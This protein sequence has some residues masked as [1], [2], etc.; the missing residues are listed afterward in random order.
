M[1]KYLIDTS[2]IIEKVP[3]KL[4]KEKKLSGEII[5]TN[6]SMSE[7]ENQANRRQEIGFIG[8][9]EIQNLQKIKSKTIQLRFVGERP[10]PNQIKFAKAGEI[11]AIIREHA[12]KEE[13]TLITA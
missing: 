4:I 12:V 3:S 5:I 9:E 13:A 6:A 7:L 8:L 11:D 10:T 2:A 1:K